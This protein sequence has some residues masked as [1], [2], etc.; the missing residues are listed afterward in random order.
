MKASKNLSVPCVRYFIALL[1]TY[2]GFVKCDPKIVGKK[3]KGE[4]LSSIGIEFIDIN[5]DLNK[6]IELEVEV[7]AD[8][9]GFLEGPVLINDYILF[10]EIFTQNIW[11]YDISKNSIELWHNYG[12]ELG[13]GGGCSGIAYTKSYPDEI[14]LACMS[15]NK[16][17]HVNLTTHDIMD[18]Y[19]HKTYHVE[20]DTTFQPNDIVV[21]NNGNVYFTD[22]PYHRNDEQGARGGVYHINRETKRMTIIQLIGYGPN[23]IAIN[24]DQ[25]MIVVGNFIDVPIEDFDYT[26]YKQ[27][28]WENMFIRGYKKKKDESNGLLEMPFDYFLTEKEPYY[29]YMLH[30]KYDMFFDS[31][32][33]DKYDN[34]WQ[35][36]Y[37]NVGENGGQISVLRNDGNTGHDVK[38]IGTIRET[39]S[40]YIVNN[41]EMGNDDYMY[42]TC[43]NFGENKG[44]LVRYKIKHVDT[45]QEL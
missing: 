19:D 10:T 33:F 21:D 3:Y 42:A 24:N 31:N 4:D 7:L 5:G 45:K 34:L 12:D 23:G 18:T 13:T 9:F 28:N 40:I 37:F 35:S 27:F 30:D 32:A 26:N 39:N 15:A 43:G 38:Y 14:W 22:L 44:S 29:G 36:V 16:V 11:K 25:S 20:R 41:L 1:I 8:S 6:L 17:L 2:A